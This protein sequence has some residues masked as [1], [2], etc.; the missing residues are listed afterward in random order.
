MLLSAWKGQESHCKCSFVQ[1]PACLCI[2]RSGQAARAKSSLP[3]THMSGQLE[4]LKG[5][6]IFKA[7]IKH[8]GMACCCPHQRLWLRTVKFCCLRMILGK[9]SITAVLSCVHLLAGFYLAIA[10]EQFD[11][12]VLLNAG[13]LQRNETPVVNHSKIHVFLPQRC[14]RKTERMR[15]I[16][17]ILLH[18]GK[19]KH[20]SQAPH[21]PIDS[22]W[23]SSPC[24]HTVRAQSPEELVQI[25]LP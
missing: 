19:Q 5:R 17:I 15:R 13:Y 24:P 21:L 25:A 18:H 9:L 20:K 4:F 11:F 12:Q 2:M 7:A 16:A 1:V 23:F 14:Q 10:F 22:R 6:K 8:R 3:G